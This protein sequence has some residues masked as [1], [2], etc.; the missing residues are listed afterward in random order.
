M[1]ISKKIKPPLGLLH[2]VVILGINDRDCAGYFAIG[3]AALAW[4]RGVIS[5]Y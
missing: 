3:I 5:L 2:N 4:H 1:V